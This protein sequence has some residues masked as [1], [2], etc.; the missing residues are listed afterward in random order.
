FLPAA[1]GQLLPVAVDLRLVIAI[2]RK[3]DRLAELEL[4]AAVQ[5]GNGRAVKL[6]RNDEHLALLAGARG[7]GPR[8]A[9]DLRI[10]EDRDIEVGGLFGLL[11][12]P[13]ERADLEGH[14]VYSF[15]LLHGGRTT[16]S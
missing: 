12:E 8:H 15:G 3:R 2:D 13:Q 1:G 14:V 16:R 6:E 10:P 4:R 11:V 5:R 9:G 7:R